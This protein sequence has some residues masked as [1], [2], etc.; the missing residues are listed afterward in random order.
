MT[1]KVCDMRSCRAENAADSLRT[2]ADEASRP[3]GALKLAAPSDSACRRAARE[4]KPSRRARFSP[5]R[6]PACRS[7]TAIRFCPADT[8]SPSRTNTLETM[9][10]SK[11]CTSCCLPEGITRPAVCTTRSTCAMA[12]HKSMAALLIHTARMTA[13]GM[14][15]RRCRPN[16]W[17]KC[18][19]SMA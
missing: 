12:I 13:R 10:P 5:R 6:A 11:C 18:S 2:V 1:R 19:A 8:W 3:A 9:P 4:I 14:R 15:K 7:D 17:S 16:D